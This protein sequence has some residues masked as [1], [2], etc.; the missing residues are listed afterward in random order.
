MSRSSHWE[1]VRAVVEQSRQDAA[2]YDPD[3]GDPDVCIERGVRPIVSLYVRAHRNGESL[4]DVE[5]SL[6]SSL[7]NDWLSLYAQAQSD[8]LDADFTVH[9]VATAYVEST[10]LR[11]AVRDLTNLPSRRPQD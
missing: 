4:S 6:L 3:G 8:H 5:R 1:E 9:E 10:S 7:L 2:A 11:G